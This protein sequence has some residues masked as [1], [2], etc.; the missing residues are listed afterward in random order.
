MSE[1]CDLVTRNVLRSFRPGFLIDVPSPYGTEQPQDRTGGTAGRDQRAPGYVQF[2]GRWVIWGE[3]QKFGGM[4]VKN[5]YPVWG[6]RSK[7]VE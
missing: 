6:S 5:Q 2:S 7:V 3:K 1:T 4:F